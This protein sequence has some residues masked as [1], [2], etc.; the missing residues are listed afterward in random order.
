[1]TVNL[2]QRDQAGIT[3]ILALLLLAMMMGVAFV[4]SGLVVRQ[5][6]SA[7]AFDDSLSA[8]YAA[9][10]GMEQ[11]LDVLGESRKDPS[12]I[13]GLDDTLTAIQASA[14]VD[15][16][17]TFSNSQYYFADSS[18]A[19]ADEVTVT[20]PFG[21]AVAIDYYPPDNGFDTSTSTAESLRL[22]WN[23]TCTQQFGVELSFSDFAASSGFGRADDAVFKQ[24]V[25]C[26]PSSD[27]DYDC[28]AVSNHLTPLQNSVIRI[29]GLDCS[30]PNAQ[31]V[32]YDDDNAGGDAVV[33]PSVVEVVSVG[34][35]TE[36]SRSL[37]TTTKWTTSAS[38]LVDFVLFAI[39][40]IDKS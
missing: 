23:Q 18:G 31:V 11:S 16:P 34:T 3:L 24:V 2:Q 19:G 15:D 10:S 30:L 35:S 9:E 25:Q 29:S 39:E 22:Q 12:L 33:I 7:R 17:I 1:M 36:A 8:L 6:Q 38:G 26:T 21:A 5:I 20:I 32:L 37:R 28:V 14:S 27:P 13:G 4:V 40:E